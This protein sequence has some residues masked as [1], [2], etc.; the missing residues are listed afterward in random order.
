MK[1]EILY[2]NARFLLE[3]ITGLQRMGR[4][5][6][7]E[8][9][10]MLAE[11]EIDRNRRKIR[12]LLPAKPK[13]AP[14]YDHLE[15]WIRGPVGSH[16]W[17][18]SLLPFRAKGFLLNLKNTAPVM[19]GPMAVAIHDLQTF[20]K[21]EIF[22]KKLVRLYQWILPRAAKRAR[23]V[24]TISEHSK[25]EIVRWLGIPEEK[26]VVIS[27]GHEHILDIESEP[28]ILQRHEIEPGSYLLAV[29]SMNPNKNFAAVPKA[30]EIGDLGDIP[31]V[32]AGGMNP[33][34]F[35]QSTQTTLPPGSIH[36]GR[37]S[38]GELRALYENALG[39]IFPSFYEGFG[40]PPLEA[41]AL[42]CP[43]ISSH[44]SSLPEVCGNAALYCDPYDHADIARQILRLA[45]DK[46][47]R[48]ELSSKG[49]IRAAGFRWRD[50]ARKI[51]QYVEPELSK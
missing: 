39:F 5:I 2:V 47:L 44:T 36:V 25:K 40:L 46:P 23:W 17:E 24:F 15:R 9:D 48:Q 7:Q 14:Q 28:E 43:V 30:L 41:M 13:D 18:Q 50:G 22:S 3:P 38:D 16:L 8:F 19:G 27:T 42:G 4:Q 35:E 1:P 32:I 29:S 21:P 11:G 12:L 37:V 6:I 45:H 49:K 33:T 26:I 34:V 10:R 51:W 20:A 31:F